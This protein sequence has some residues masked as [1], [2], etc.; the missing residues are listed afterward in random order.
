MR[1]VDTNVLAR[2]IVR[3]DV[4]QAKIADAALAGNVF[5]PLTVL[6]ETAW[7]L[8]NRYRIERGA[9]ADTLLD[10]LDLPNVSVQEPEAIRW[11]ID[12]YRDGGDIADA[13]HLVASIHSDSFATFDSAMQKALR[14]PPVPIEV[15]T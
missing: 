5:V 11:A 10:I 12:R 2:A 3:D 1:A 4:A 15:L 7:L 9:V 8:G 6:L 14:D 13:F